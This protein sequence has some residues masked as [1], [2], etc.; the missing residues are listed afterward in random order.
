MS[1]NL[2]IDTLS[3]A[4]TV[5]PAI[6]GLTVAKLRYRGISGSAASL[7]TFI[8]VRG[9]ILLSDYIGGIL[10]KFLFS[11]DTIIESIGKLTELS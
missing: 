5:D 10:S 11:I 4:I 6:R 7:N 8:V 3:L 2:S 1:M 9:T